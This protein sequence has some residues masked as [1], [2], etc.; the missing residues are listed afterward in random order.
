MKMFFDEDT[1]DLL[2][3]GTCSQFL[4]PA[5]SRLQNLS[6]FHV[7]QPEANEGMRETKRNS[8]K[9]RGPWH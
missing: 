6:E 7:Q 8:L 3:F 9:I 5:L 1:M 4:G 2:K